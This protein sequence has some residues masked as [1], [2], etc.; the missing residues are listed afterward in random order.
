MAGRT[1]LRSTSEKKKF[2]KSTASNVYMY[3]K[4]T[5]P[6]FSRR[7]KIYKITLKFANE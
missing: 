1:N 6:W 7:E 3:V 4:K 2:L 5:H